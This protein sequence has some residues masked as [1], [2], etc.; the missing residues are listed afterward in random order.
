MSGWERIGPPPVVW[1][2]TGCHAR[3]CVELAVVLLDGWPFCLD[4]AG[5]LV[6]RWTAWELNPELVASMPALADR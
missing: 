5:D 2:L 4:C 3:H 6:D 1:G